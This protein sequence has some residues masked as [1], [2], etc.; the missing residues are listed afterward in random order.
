[1]GV[2]AVA[3][4]FAATW[5]ALPPVARSTPLLFLGPGL[6]GAC[7]AFCVSLALRAEKAVDL[8]TLQVG[9]TKIIV[10]ACLPSRLPDA[11]ALI[12]PTSTTLRMRGGLPGA[13]S[14]AAGSAVETEVLQSAPTGMGKVV[15]TGAGRLPVGRVIHVAVY[16]PPHRVEATTLRRG[17]EAAC[18]QARK[19]GA[20]SLVIPVG[21]WRGLPVAE[22]TRVIAEAALKQRKAFGE[23]VF[24]VFEPPLGKIVQ[25]A[26]EQAVTAAAAS[27]VGSGSKKGA[28]RSGGAAA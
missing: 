18:Q 6:M 9:D 20:E 19:A 28:A 2:A 5:A 17:I 7:A 13:I 8:A 21:G 10:R 4:W 23:I 16:E 15:V 25:T 22:A 1:V 11:D 3:V 12:L 27:G 24:A 14:T 26:V